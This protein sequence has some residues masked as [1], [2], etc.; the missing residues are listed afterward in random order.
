MRVQNTLYK[1]TLLCMYFFKN[2]MEPGAAEFSGHLAILSGAAET[3]G[4][5]AILSKAAKI[6]GFWQFCRIP[7]LQILA[8]TWQFCPELRK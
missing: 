2:F 5:L 4:H 8:T 3:S 1:F 7:K 6:S